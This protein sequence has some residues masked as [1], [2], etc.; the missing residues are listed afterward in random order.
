MRSLGLL[1]LR[2]AAGTVLIGHGYTKLFGGRGK[3]APEALESVFGPNFPQAVEETGP[4]KF[5]E[6]LEQIEVPAPRAA[7]V[8]SGIAEFGGGLAFVLGLKTRMAAPAVL[9][10]MGT[11]IRKVH[12]SRGMYGEGGFEF[13]LM[14]AAAAATLFFTGPGVF[15]LDAARSAG[16][17][18][19]GGDDD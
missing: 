14:L 10:N 16:K 6:A 18:I 12:W 2:L 7:A 5:A 13:P 19:T 17:K 8:A 9:I 4:E 1:L 3:R 11:A 15:S